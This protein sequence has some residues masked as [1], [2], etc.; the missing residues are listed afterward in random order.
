V[1]DR[2]AAIAGALLDELVALAI[3]G[4]PV[5]QCGLLIGVPGVVLR[6]HPA[7]NLD[8]SPRRYTVN[9]AD[10]FAALR[11]ARADGLTVIGAWHSHPAGPAIPSA[12][13]R[14][15]AAP[16]FLYLIVGL[17]PAPDV[18]AWQL[19]DGNFV[20]RHLVRT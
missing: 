13:D 17:V 5:E 2:P 14:A 3:A 9:P 4:A 11:A 7:R 15:E 1:T 19:V 8:A 10:H 6:A 18:R 16:D 20:P 12:T